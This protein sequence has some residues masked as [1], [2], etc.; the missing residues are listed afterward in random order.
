M[1]VQIFPALIDDNLEAFAV[2][3]RGDTEP[4]DIIDPPQTELT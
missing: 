1:R 3:P 2:A 4:G